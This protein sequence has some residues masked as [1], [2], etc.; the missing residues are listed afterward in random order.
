MGEGRGDAG[1]VEPI[2]VRKG[3]IP[4]DITDDGLSHRGS[5]AVIDDLARTLIRAGLE[6]VDAEAAGTANDLL[7]SDTEA[8]KFSDAGIRNGVLGQYGEEFRGDTEGTKRDRDIGL[9]A[10]EGRLE[11]RL[12]KKAVVFSCL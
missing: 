6:V 4:V 9:A 7:G 5:L 12:L 8:S 3:R 1:H 2:D 11:K 10:P